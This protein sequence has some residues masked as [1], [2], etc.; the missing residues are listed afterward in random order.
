MHGAGASWW[1]VLVWHDA[2]MDDGGRRGFLVSRYATRTLAPR[3]WFGRY[4]R[5]RSQSLAVK[6]P[7]LKRA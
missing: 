5:R 2:E 6:W 7:S 3:T 1:G 4:V